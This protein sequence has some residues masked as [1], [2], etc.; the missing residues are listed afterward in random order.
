MAALTGNERAR[1]AEEFL[2]VA[3][4]KLISFNSTS[5]KTGTS[6]R[7]RMRVFAKGCPRHAI[8]EVHERLARQNPLKDPVIDGVVQPGTYYHR[9][10]GYVKDERTSEAGTATYTIVRDYFDGP[11]SETDVVE[12]GCGGKTTIRF[13]WD[14]D[15]V[16][17]LA[18]LVNSLGGTGG[19]SPQGTVVRIAGVN[20]DQETGLFSY[21]VT[22]TETKTVLV[23]EFL[24]SEDAFSRDKEAAWLGLRGTA[25]SPIDSNTDSAPS[26]AVPDPASQDDGT[27][28]TVSWTKN[29]DDCTLNAQSRKRVAKQDVAAAASCVKTLFEERDGAAVRAAAS[30]LGHAPAP[31]DG[32]IVS[33]RDTLRPDNLWDTDK[34]ET[35][36]L[37]VP[38]ARVS[39]EVTAFETN[40]VTL[41]R[42]QAK[43]SAP[44]ASAAGGII[45]SP[46]VEKTPGD[47]ENVTVGVRTEL[48]GPRSASDS[49]DQFSE[50]RSEEDVNAVPL[51]AAPAAAAGVIVT[52]SDNNTPG[53]LYAR[54]KTT[55]VEKPGPRAV[56]KADNAFESSAVTDDVSATA[57]G[58]PPAAAAGVVTSHS[59]RR[60]PGGLFQRRKTVN[61]EKTGDRG[62]VS[63]KT[64]FDVT[65]EEADVALAPLG[66]APPAAG[67]VIVTHSDSNTPGGLVSRRKKTVRETSV[68]GDSE[69]T[70]VTP[71]GTFLTV[72]DKSMPVKKS[73]PAGAFG[74]VRNSLTPGGMYD[75]STTQL[76]PGSVAAGT[77]LSHTKGGNK[78]STVEVK[79]TVETVKDFGVTGLTNDGVPGA[80]QI[81]EVDFTLQEDGT[82]RKRETVRTASDKIWVY[83]AATYIDINTNESLPD[84]TVSVYHYQFLNATPAEAL[85]L[86]ELDVGASTRAGVRISY[87]MRLNEFGLY[88][89]TF[90]RVVKR[91]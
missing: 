41:S 8:R 69:D 35:Q 26:P 81:R 86:L 74:T 85:A 29:R 78:F 34:D 16:E 12:D 75:R 42:S 6:P 73:L 32:K 28:A 14:R 24:A 18:T 63:A 20:R 76:V 9:G 30:P 58:D 62:A 27:L 2:S 50:E 39:T 88:S 22:V 13:E 37:S 23:P 80:A 66:E 84:V 87:D 77:V 5:A 47:R 51:G 70:R 4:W 31:S 1:Q 72:T 17:D 54:R 21:Y 15:E 83:A 33:H 46:T 57:L 38:G 82:Y 53:G 55:R 91:E 40:V 10:A 3:V 68:E 45:T 67:G 11:V 49:E 25:S 36:E 52:H 61:T 79:E 90:R 44:A 59:D 65:E 71:W 7:F 60:T 89:G 43:G 64:A 48:P 56:D 19:V